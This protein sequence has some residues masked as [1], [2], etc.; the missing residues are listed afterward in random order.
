MWFP[1][2]RHRGPSH[3]HILPTPSWSQLSPYQP[4]RRLSSLIFCLLCF[5]TKPRCAR[6]TCSQAF[7]L[8]FMGSRF[9]LVV[10]RLMLIRSALPHL[11]RPGA[12][13]RRVHPPAVGDELQHFLV[14]ATW[15]RHVAQ[16]EDLPQQ[17]PERPAGDERRDNV[18]GGG[19]ATS[20]TK[21]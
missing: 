10:A 20:G 11:H 17:N 2:W 1:D 6:L 14:T 8:D 13:L 16:G 18:R 21:L 4:H 3:P 7:L 19:G 5:F 12:V 15:I 9:S